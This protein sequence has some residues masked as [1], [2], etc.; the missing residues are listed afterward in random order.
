MKSVVITQSNYI[1]WKGYFDQIRCADELVLYDDAQFTRRDWRNRNKIKT[2]NGLLW[3][4]VPVEVKGKF[5]QK[6][7]DTCV[8]DGGWAK[9][10]L[11][12]IQA[13]YGKAKHYK[14][15]ISAIE[16]AYAEAAEMKY[17]SDINFCMISCLSQLLSITTP[18]S[19]SSDY[20]L[21]DGKTERLA[22]ICEQLGATHY[23]SGP[24]AKDYLDHA[25]F[26][27][28][29]VTVQYF[30]Y[31][32]YPEYPQLH[33]DFEH[34]VSIIDLLFNMGAEAISYMKSDPL[35]PG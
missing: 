21:V 7:K 34:A 35:E 26:E 24:A 30:D 8:A 10:H 31:S 2:P 23:Y 28:R 11:K 15:F 22:S 33:G 29:G 1:P 20:D 32:G 25:V 14:E 4:T 16:D 13:A 19:R 5:S 6:I 9:K 12:S 27:S 17:L 18:I 3:L